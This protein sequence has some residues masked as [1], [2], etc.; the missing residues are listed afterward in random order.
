LESR[1][2][3]ENEALRARLSQELGA[4]E[5]R[6]QRETKQL[7]ERFQT[8]KLVL[9]RSLA[10]TGERLSEVEAR[11]QAVTAE[12]QRTVKAQES[13]DGAHKEKLAALRLGE[14]AN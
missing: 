1:W 12:L 3:F 7:G 9:S 5:A 10:A 8:E 14:K 2:R 11:K 4:L 6:H 13:A